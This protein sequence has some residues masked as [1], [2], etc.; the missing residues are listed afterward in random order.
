[1]KQY[2]N[3]HDAKIQYNKV[4]KSLYLNIFID[5]FGIFAN[6]INYQYCKYS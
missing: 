4:L 5:N 2:V 3:K 6:I 1:M